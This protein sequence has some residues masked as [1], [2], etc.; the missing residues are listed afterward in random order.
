MASINAYDTKFNLSIVITMYDGWVTPNVTRR[1][2]Y[3]RNLD[4]NTQAQQ[5]EHAK[6][7][8]KE[9]AREI[10]Y[11]TGVGIDKSVIKVSGKKA[12]EN[13]FQLEPH[14]LFRHFK[15]SVKIRFSSISS[16]MWHKDGKKTWRISETELA[17]GWEKIQVERIGKSA[18]FTLP[19][20]ALTS[21]AQGAPTFLKFQEYIKRRRG[22]R[23]TGWRVSYNHKDANL[24]S[25]LS[26]FYP[27]GNISLGDHRYF[28]KDI[29]FTA[30]EGSFM[31]A[32]KTKRTKTPRKTYLASQ[33]TDNTEFVYVIQ[34]GQK[35]IFKI[36]KS[37][38]PEGRLANLQTASPFKLKLLHVFSADNASIA[39]ENLHAALHEKRLKGEWFRL[40]NE[41]KASIVSVDKFVEGNFIVG[42]QELSV[43]ELLKS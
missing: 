37:N 10:H 30:I 11:I 7:L 20:V 33:P 2:F 14:E 5:I 17:E 24:L 35:N 36:G 27:D 23:I 1:T 40:T 13:I 4:G 22:R 38:D 16:F 39:E 9:F 42:K 3:L 12:A 19:C 6:D 31:P 32:R 25:F 43:K 26:K 34:M 18:T 8:S 29:R 15:H 21:R 28:G 41:Q